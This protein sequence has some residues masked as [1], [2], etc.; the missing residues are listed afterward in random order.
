MLRKKKGAQFKFTFFCKKNTMSAGST[1][2]TVRERS[3][4]YGTSWAMRNTAVLP[5]AL[6]DY[7]NGNPQA[8]TDIEVK[9]YDRA[10]NAMR[11]MSLADIIVNFSQKVHDDIKPNGAGQVCFR[12]EFYVSVNVLSIVKAVWL[13]LLIPST[14]ATGEREQ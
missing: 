9:V 3:E 8:C 11:T 6:H 12:E 4:R 2:V 10:Q 5:R 7:K 14:T 13:T 1:H